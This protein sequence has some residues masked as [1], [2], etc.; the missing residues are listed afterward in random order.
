MTLAKNEL[1]I[2]TIE[3]KI[4]LVDFMTPMMLLNGHCRSH[5][6]VSK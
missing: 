6:A 2:E 4:G 5:Y 3:K 1:G